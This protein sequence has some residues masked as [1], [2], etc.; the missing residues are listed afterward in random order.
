MPSRN[1]AYDWM[2]A[3]KAGYDWLLAGCLS[4]SGRSGRVSLVDLGPGF[5]NDSGRLPY[6]ATDQL[7]NHTMQPQKY[8]IQTDEKNCR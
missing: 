1:M 7:L 8:G 4:I 3:R 2:V 5:T 6:T